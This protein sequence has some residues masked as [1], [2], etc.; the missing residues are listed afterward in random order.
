MEANAWSEGARRTPGRR[1]LVPR[2]REVHGR[3]C[4]DGGALRAAG[5][6]VQASDHRQRRVRQRVLGREGQAWILAPA[7]FLASHV[8]TKSTHLRNLSSGLASSGIL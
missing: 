6:C 5:Q 7:L 2:S 3:S 1:G 4:T 8:P